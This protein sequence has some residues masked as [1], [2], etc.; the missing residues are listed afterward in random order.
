MK[1]CKHSYTDIIEIKIIEPKI[2]W[3]IVVCSKCL[4][5]KKTISFYKNE[6]L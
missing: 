1:K 2:I 4:K 5:E 3:K 6:T